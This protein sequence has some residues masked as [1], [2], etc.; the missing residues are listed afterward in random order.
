MILVGQE[1]ALRLLVL[2]LTVLLAVQLLTYVLPVIVDGVA[3]NA[4]YQVVLF[5]TV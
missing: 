5:L 2:Y 3:T 4:Q 1:I